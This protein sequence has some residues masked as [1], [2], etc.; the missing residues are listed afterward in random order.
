MISARSQ[1]GV[2]LGVLEFDKKKRNGGKEKSL[3][4]Q[5]ELGRRD[6]SLCPWK[7]FSEIDGLGAG[8][9]GPEMYS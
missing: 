8:G 2:C 7:L 1:R 9:R 5:G 3:G 6:V 4:S